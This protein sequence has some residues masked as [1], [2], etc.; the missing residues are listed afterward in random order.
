MVFDLAICQLCK[1]MPETGQGQAR[2]SM[3]KAETSRDKAGSNRDAQG[4]S[5]CVPVCPWLSLSIPVS[6]CLLLSVAVC[7]CLSLPVPVSP[8]LSL[9]VSVCS[10]LSLSVSACPC[11]YLSVPVCQSSLSTFG[12][13][14]CL[15]PADKYHSLHQYEHS[16]TNCDCKSHCVNLC[17]PM[18]F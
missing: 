14:E 17:K 11:L 4:Q 5:L 13:P 6:L 12:I 2:T 8:C 3:D 15:P 1:L 18:Y 9:S 16:Y 10:F 7:P